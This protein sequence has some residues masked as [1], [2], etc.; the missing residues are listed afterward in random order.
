VSGHLAIPY[1]GKCD[2]R[3]IVRAEWV[4]GF[5]LLGSLLYTLANTWPLL[6]KLIQDVF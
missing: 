1:F 6:N 3:W 2:L 5:F 4:I